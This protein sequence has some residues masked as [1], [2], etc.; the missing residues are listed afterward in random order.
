MEPQKVFVKEDGTTVIKCPSCRHA[1]TVSVEKFKEKKKIIKVKC[2]CKESYFVSLELRKMY[3]KGTSLKGTYINYSLNNELGM[4]IVKDISMGG[5][6]FEVIGGNRIKKDHELEVTFTLDDTH[7]SVIKKKVVVRI[8][9]K[10]FVG[11]EFKHAHEYNKALGFY[12]R[13]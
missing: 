2:S 10:N 1:R 4:M 9:N 3:R 6:G 13:P 8:V 7:S 5:V 11:C 12:L